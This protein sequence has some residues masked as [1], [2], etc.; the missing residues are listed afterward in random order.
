M[1]FK[2]TKTHFFIALA[3]C[4]SCTFSYS[5]TDQHIQKIYQQIPKATSLQKRI[6]MI[7]EN[8]LNKPY[9]LGALGEGRNGQFDQSPIYRVNGFDCATYVSTVLSLSL[10]SDLR[11]FRYKILEVRY[12]NNKADYL[13]RNHFMSLDWIPNNIKKGFL[14]DI[15]KTFKDKEGHHLY[16]TATVNIDKAAWLQKK[17]IGDIKVKSN[18]AEQLK[19]LKQYAKQYPV[20]QATTY[21]LPLSKLFNKSGNANAYVFNQIPTS[22]II[23][24]IR[25]NWNMKN[26]IGT[27]LNV[28]HLGFAI[29]KNQ[30]LYFREASSKAKRV[31]DTPLALYLKRYLNSPTIKGIAVLMPTR[32]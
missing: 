17:D 18:Q 22:S 10:A 3:F 26:K 2:Q 1:D 27:N 32:P 20:R 29:K 19:K 31:I 23:E 15:T 11:T 12:A 21:Y 8:F 25:P 14:K 30:T 9:V 4:S 13:D 5:K 6:E 7:S 16:Q 28:S 24:I